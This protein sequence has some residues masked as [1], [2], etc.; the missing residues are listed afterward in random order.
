VLNRFRDFK[1]ENTN[2]NTK[3]RRWVGWG[4][5]FF[6]MLNNC[7]LLR[8]LHEFDEV[9]EKDVTVAIAETFHFVANFSGVMVNSEA[10]LP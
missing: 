10:G 5:L 2:E 7:V 1:R 6:F 8:I 3:E 9:V 4:R